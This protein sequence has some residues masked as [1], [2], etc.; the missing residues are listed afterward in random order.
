[1]TDKQHCNFAASIRCFNYLH[2]GDALD[3]IPEQSV[4]ELLFPIGD[5]DIAPF[6]SGIDLAQQVS[7]HTDIPCHAL[8][9]A[10]HPERHID[11]CAKAGCTAMT[12][13]LEA[14]NH[15]HRI[16]SAIRDAGMKAG[17]AINPATSLISLDYL[18][19]KADCICLLGVEPGQD[20]NE[21]A[22]PALVERVK[23]VSENIRYRELLTQILV[24]GGIT[25]TTMSRT[26][27]V[28]ASTIGITPEMLSEAGMPSFPEALAKYAALM[29]LL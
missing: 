11:A 22:K 4:S 17:I 23:M 5:G 19:E 13:S 26:V 6:M 21:T 29:Q 14:S 27:T 9:L 15:Q 7:V 3:V 24:Y 25:A 1:M 18:L 10:R 20:K 8:L 2:L 16:L 12:I 28:G